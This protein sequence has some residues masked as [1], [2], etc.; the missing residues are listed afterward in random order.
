MAK[1][2]KKQVVTL[3]V[4]PRI[5]SGQY[6]WC[7]NCGHHGNFGFFRKNN[8]KCEI[9]DYDEPLITSIE[10]INDPFLDNIW[11]ERYRTKKQVDSGVPEQT[12]EDREVPTV[13]ESK[14]I[15]DKS[16]LEKLAKIRNLT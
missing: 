3:P 2:R 6:Y 11:I 15:K 7:V 8:V 16:V 14:D 12:P 5:T 4:E 13:T 10:D 1:K 9:C